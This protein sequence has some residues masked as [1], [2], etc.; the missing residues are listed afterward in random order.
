MSYTRKNREDINNNEAKLF[1]HHVLSGTGININAINNNQAT[2][3]IKKHL[4][5]SVSRLIEKNNLNKIGNIYRSK[6][7]WNRKRKENKGQGINKKSMQNKSKN[8]RRQT[9]NK[10]NRSKKRHR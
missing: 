1:R 6:A 3:A 4:A 7:A 10:R 5:S 8:K 9:K 2:K